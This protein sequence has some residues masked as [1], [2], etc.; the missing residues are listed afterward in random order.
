MSDPVATAQPAADKARLWKISNYRPFGI[1]ERDPSESTYEWGD[2]KFPIIVGV[3]G[4]LVEQKERAELIVRA[5]NAY[6]PA[7][8]AAVDALTETAAPLAFFIEQFDRQPIRTADDFYGIHTGTEYEASLR[9][10]DLRKLA[11][12][13]KALEELRTP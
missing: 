3:R 6:D 9:L 11:A 4:S 10:S 2:D 7:Q 5:V 8:S 12:A 13:L 1:I